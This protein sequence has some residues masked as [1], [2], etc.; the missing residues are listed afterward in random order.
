MEKDIIA[1]KTNTLWNKT[2]APRITIITSNYNRRDALY[3]CMKSVDAQTCRDIE[4]IVVDNGST[5]S[6]DDIMEKFMSEATIPVMF[7]KRSSGFGRHTGRNS[8]IK[9]ARGELLSIIDSD[10]EFLPHCMDTLLRAWDTIP[11]VKRRDYREVVA[12]CEDEYGKQI[13]PCFPDEFN[14]ST[15]ERV[16]KLVQRSG[17][18]VEHAS[19]QRTDIMKDNLFLDPEGVTDSFES[20]I[21]KKLM[22]RYRSFFINDIVK[23]YYTANP[24]SITNIYKKGLTKNACISYLFKDQYYLNHWDEYLFPFSQRIK[25]ILQYLSWKNILN[26]YQVNYDFDWARQGL[27]GLVNNSLAI[28]LWLPSHLYT[29]FFL[30][31]RKG[32]V[33]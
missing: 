5:V 17:Y 10:D 26:K 1:I 11:K 7:I 3:R 6:F 4:Y 25:T 9:E 32:F 33:N 22:S 29:W 31:Y 2:K 28:I 13:G 15:I 16:F 30:K 18:G 20:I 8:A 19:L 23:R 12:L 27:K 21:W 14:S 24:D